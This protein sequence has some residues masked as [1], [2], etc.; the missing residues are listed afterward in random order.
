MTNKRLL[1]ILALITAIILICGLCVFANMFVGNPV[2]RL[3][4]YKK[5]EEYLETHYLETPYF[6]NKVDYSFKDGSYYARI[7][8]PG[9]ADNYF[10]ISYNSSGRLIYC[11]YE[12][13]V[14][15]RLNVAYRLMNEY[16]ERMIPIIKLAVRDAG[17]N[18]ILN[19]DDDS[20]LRSSDLEL[21]RVYDVMELGRLGGSISADISDSDITPQNAAKYLLHIKKTVEDCGGAFA[22]INLTIRSD[23][24]AA[25]RLYLF[26]FPYSEIYEEGL[27]ERIEAAI[28][29]A[30]PDYQDK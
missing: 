28:E 26:D 3:I 14:E 9:S 15:N 6:V 18:G 10:N 5:A 30:Q 21:D 12:T 17:A 23:D 27:A 8:A 20:S 19:F 25:S 1:K 24:D 13:L 4:V 7:S 29:K 16:R 22:D 11:D 2:S